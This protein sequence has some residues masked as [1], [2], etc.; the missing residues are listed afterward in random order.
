[1]MLRVAFF[2]QRS[3]QSDRLRGA[4]SGESRPVALSLFSAVDPLFIHSSTRD[5]LWNTTQ[6]TT[7]LQPSTVPVGTILICQRH[8]EM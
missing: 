8:L 6:P 3:L 1:M 5:V 7:A 2:T 4:N